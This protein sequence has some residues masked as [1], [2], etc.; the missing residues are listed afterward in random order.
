MTKHILIVEDEALAGRVL[1]EN[2]QDRGFS[3]HLS[4]TAE[5]AL[6]YFS[7]NRVD[8]LLLDYKLPGMNGEELFQKIRSIHPMV[9]AIFMTA[10]SSVEKAVKL[11]KMGA[12]DY[13]TKPIEID[14]LNYTIDRIIEKMVLESENSRLKEQ[15]Q[16]KFSFENYIFNSDRMQE[17]LNITLRAAVSEAN[18]LITGNSGTGKE[19]IAN[20]I[21]FQSKRKNNP[22]VKVNLSALPES[23]IE[24]ELFG[25]EKGAYTGSIDKRIGKFEEAH[26][27]T[28]FLDE[29]G[30]LPLEIQVKLLRALQERE[31]SRI[32]SNKVIKTDIRLITATNRKLEE[33]IDQGL[34]REDLFYRLN[35]ININLPDLVD[36]KT[37]IPLLVDYFIKKFSRRE[38]KKI[39]SISAD[40][41]SALV[42]YHYKGNIRE[43]ENIVER[44]V[45][46]ARDDVLGIG[47]LPIHILPGEDGGN[48]MA[49]L[50]FDLPLPEKLKQIEKDLI[51]LALKKCEF[52]QSRA[53]EALGIS[54]SGLRYKMQHLD[55]IRKVD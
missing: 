13:I 36:R 47:D 49:A 48:Q 1:L 46:L 53:A 32:G 5:D 18:I 17:A 22:F 52:N 23:L 12:S 26:G 14:E 50:D 2:F 51:I 4:L 40:A 15:L 10:Y 37:D 45:V 44:A 55:I 31:I 3:A 54:E 38:G 29:I 6:R 41:M 20:I 43:L 39:R 25:A 30:D 16:D 9:P 21:H 28:L 24:A 8:I 11:L 19:V 27:G 33:R 35:V 42:K 34:F 7:E